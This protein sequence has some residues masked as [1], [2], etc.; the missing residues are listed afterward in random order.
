MS[1]EE[2]IPQVEIPQ[3]QPVN[4]EPTDEPI[5]SAEPIAEVEQP[6]TLNP[7]PSTVQE[8]EVH[9][10]THAAHGKKKWKS[11]FWEFLM[12]FLAVFCG[13]LAEYQLEHKIEKD[14]GKELAKSLYE[15]L[16]N[17]SVVVTLKVQNRIKQENALLYLGDYFKDSSLTQVSKTFTLNFYY[18]L[19]FRSPAIFE[20]RTVVLEQLKNSGSLRYFKNV[21]LQRLIS[22]LSVAIQNVNDRQA[23]ENSLRI[24]YLNPLIIQHHDYNFEMILR[25][26]KQ[27]D[28]FSVIK[29]YENSNEII[30]FYFKA[31]EKFDKIRAINIMSFYSLS[32]M[33]S[34]RTVHLKRYM[35]LNAELLKLLRNKYHLE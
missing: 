22:D 15:D 32:G 34:T 35:D 7:Q 21:D 23:L 10:L 14:R 24:E 11:Y 25:K 8:M 33:E 2:K 29:D 27:T 12:L 5:S 13:F 31:I 28:I 20:P 26:R 3:K 6:L 1:E 17:D 19:L 18:G 30:P 4:N 16:K 9:H